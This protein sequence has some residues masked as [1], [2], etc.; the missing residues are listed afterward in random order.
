MFSL[1]LYPDPSSHSELTVTWFVQT[2]GAAYDYDTVIIGLMIAINSMFGLPFLVAATVRSQNHVHA[3]AEK[4]P[5][6][7]I[8]S[9]QETRLTHLL[10][11][12]LCLV[13]LFALNALKLI[14]MPVLY[15]S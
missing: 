4:D 14:P 10:I 8:L 3:L 6:G 7:R 1:Y 2:H 5:Q 9:V 12:V 15:V 13:A 11:H